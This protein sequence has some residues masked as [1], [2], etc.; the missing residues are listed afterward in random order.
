MKTLFYFAVLTLFYSCTEQSTFEHPIYKSIANDS[1]LHYYELGWKQI[2]DEGHY[3]PA[4]KSY[5]KVLLHDPDFLMGKSVLGRLTLDLD[6]RLKIF[7]E[8]QGQK[9]TVT[10]D[11][12]LILDAYTALVDYTN[13][14]EQGIPGL[15]EK[16][17][18]A[19]RLVED[20]FKKIV[21][22]YPTEVYMKAEYIEFLHSAYGPK[23]ALDSIAVLTNSEQKENPFLLGY[24]ASMLA[25][26]GAFEKALK[27]AEYLKAITTEK[28]IPK[29]YAVLADVYFQMD[30]LQLAK[31]NAEKANNLDP[32]NLDASRLLEKI[33]RQLEN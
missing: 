27:K 10:G 14:R 23:K 24:Q 31:S 17:E 1:A 15:Q 8:I 16:R 18:V 25:E 11:E 2:M 30:S 3:G 9:E 12:R 4:E 29:P 6:E 7:S 33:M 20:N 32:R 5:R 21:H 22:K 26:M 13:A 19:F 28:D